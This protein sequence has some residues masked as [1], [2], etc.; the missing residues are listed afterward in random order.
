MDAALGITRQQLDAISAAYGEIVGSPAQALAEAVL[1]DPN[2]TARARAM[3]SEVQD[4]ARRGMEEALLAIYT[5]DQRELVA[6]VQAAYVRVYEAAREQM[7]NAI[8]TEFAKELGNVLTVAQRDAMLQARAA[9][10]A[11]A[12]VE[13]P[14]ADAAAATDGA[15]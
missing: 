8:R 13:E 4:E 15:H 3:A 10:E 14:A 5:L 9:I 1:A 6:K 11:A 7:A 2:A 12:Q